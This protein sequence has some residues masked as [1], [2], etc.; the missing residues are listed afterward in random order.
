MS[1]S[2]VLCFWIALEKGHVQIFF[3]KTKGADDA[4]NT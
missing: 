2:C 1:L 4:D 3:L